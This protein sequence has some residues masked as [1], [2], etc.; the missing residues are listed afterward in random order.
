TGASSLCPKATESLN[1][2]REPPTT[3]CMSRVMRTR[4]LLLAAVLGTVGLV[5]LVASLQ[6]GVAT[7]RGERLL[8]ADQ[9]FVATMDEELQLLS[10]A[11][12]DGADRLRASLEA[13]GRYE[14]A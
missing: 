2:S 5:W 8:D 11:G 9:L 4:L 7:T 3:R 12:S 13:R 14:D 10:T 1:R 6:H